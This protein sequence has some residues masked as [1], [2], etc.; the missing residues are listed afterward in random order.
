MDS[1]H[2]SRILVVD[3]DRVNQRLFQFQLAQCGYEVEVAGDGSEVVT[4]FRQNPDAY[5]LIL[6]DLDMPVMDGLEAT[7]RIRAQEQEMASDKTLPI[8]AFSSF[9][10]AVELEQCL[11]AGMSDGLHKPASIDKLRQVIAQWLP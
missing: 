9:L 6:M 4:R 7:R 5:D 10:N 3:D 2:A 11:D 1:H 8:I